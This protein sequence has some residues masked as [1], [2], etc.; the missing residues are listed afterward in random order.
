LGKKGRDLT[1][2]KTPKIDARGDQYRKIKLLGAL[3]D[4]VAIN[5]FGR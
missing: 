2:E 3:V 4:E 1:A 5:Y